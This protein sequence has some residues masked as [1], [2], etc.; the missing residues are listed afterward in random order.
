MPVVN[1]RGILTRV[2]D[3][4]V[5]QSDRIVEHRKMRQTWVETFVGFVALS[6][7]FALGC[8]LFGGL[9]ALGIFGF[10]WLAIILI[11]WFFSAEITPRAVQAYDADRNTPLGAAANRCADR[12]WEYLIAHVTENYGAH[13]A[14]QLKRPP[15]KLSPNKHA[16][17]FCTG[18]GWH[19]SVIVIF[20]GCFA[21]K[22]D[23]DELVGVLCHEL[24]H[25]FH[26][27]VFIQTIASVIGAFITL[28]AL[29][30]TQRWLQPIFGKLS[31]WLR[32][33]S[34]IGL[35]LVFRLSGMLLK[36]VTAFISR[37]R[38]ASADAFSAEITD[39]PCALNRALKKLVAYEKELARQEAQEQAELQSSNPVKFYEMQFARMC[40]HA[41]LNA[42]GM[43]MFVDTLDCLDHFTAARSTPP[44]A[45]EREGARLT[46]DHP[47]VEDRCAW[48][49]L[50]AG[51]ACPCPGYED[52]LKPM[53]A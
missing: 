18:R 24:G 29:G 6:A 39:N 20:E 22:M 44:R 32:W 3:A 17:A 40:E 10:A 26:G 33:P 5:P 1:R 31:W 27:D 52:A 41:V 13:I 46:E 16:N 45:L 53:A 47:P 42:L 8:W 7:L 43:M 30:L 37:A 36:V 49:E 50:A 9:P 23:E 12:A 15:V 2:L 28:S 25:F 51:Q 11:A 14:A 48:L 34:Y 38:E 35:Y 19:D 4:N 21:A